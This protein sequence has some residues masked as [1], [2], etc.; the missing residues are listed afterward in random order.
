MSEPI[1]ITGSGMVSAIGTNKADA[2]NSLLHEQT[3][4]GALKYLKTVHHEFPVGEVQLS[5][6]QLAALLGIAPDVPTTR[7]S[8]MGMLALREA[9]TE[10]HLLPDGRSERAES[11]P[12]RV[13]LVS[14]T[15]V[16]GMDKSEQYYPDFLSNDSRN[17]YIATHDCGACTEMIADHFGIFSFVSSISTAC[18]SAANALVEAANL[19]RDG[20]FDIVVAGGSECL[21]KFHLN[22]FNSL[23]LLERRLCRPFDRDRAGLNLGEG[24]GYL[25][26]ET[27]RSA[28]QRG[29]APV[30]LFAGYGNSCDA[31]HQTASSDDGEGAFLAMRKALADAGLEPADIDY[32]NAHGTGTVNNDASETEALKRVFG[33][34]LP[35]VSSTKSFT[36]H[37]TSASGAI[38]SVI[39]LLAMRHGFLPVNL[40]WQHAMPGGIIPVPDKHTDR[41][42]RHVLCNSFGFGGNDT[43]L[44]FS[45]PSRS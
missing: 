45:N 35:P 26:L 24:A 13:A 23:M 2:L 31:F 6:G 36:G 16:G 41:P 14:G 43:S 4:I 1:L 21:T 19:I 27:A 37:T 10:A 3:G 29:V 22:G 15:T 25:V 30:G 28:A 20:R 33:N 44:V 42:L 18:S 40:N 38:E 8:L 17:A 11:V 7:T 5:D 9:L 34:R 39:C 12:L 32:I